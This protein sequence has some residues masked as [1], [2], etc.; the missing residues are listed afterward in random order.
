MQYI[1]PTLVSR[2]NPIMQSVPFTTLLQIFLSLPCIFLLYP[3]LY[4]LVPFSALTVLVRRQEGHP[5]SKKMGGWWKWALVSPDGVAPSRMV[6]VSA[7]VLIF[8]CVRESRSSLLAPAHP[9]GP[10]KRAIKRLCVCVSI[11]YAWHLTD[12]QTF[13]IRQIFQCWYNLGSSFLHYFQ[14][15][16]ISF[17]IC[18]PN[19]GAVIKVRPNHAVV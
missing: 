7:S 12:F 3:F 14:S 5:A 9:G 6:C 16:C 15:V 11:M 13:T 4:A 10:R 17:S 19:R 1:V 2:Y 18:C 8:H